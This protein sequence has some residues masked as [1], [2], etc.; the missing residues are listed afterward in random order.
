[1]TVGSGKDGK[2]ITRSMDAVGRNGRISGKCSRRRC[3][4]ERGR[5]WVEVGGWVDTLK[6]S[7]GWIEACEDIGMTSGHLA[8][9]TGWIEAC[10]GIGMTSG[11]LADLKTDWV[12]YK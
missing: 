7:T 11:N 10:W 3:R 5:S 4:G 6:S 1:M 8:G 12:W 9:Y 2:N